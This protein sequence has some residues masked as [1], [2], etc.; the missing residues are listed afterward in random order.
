MLDFKPIPDANYKHDY[1]E[2]FAYVA[3]GKIKG[4][5]TYRSLCLDDLF[6]LLYFGLGRTDCNQSFVIDVIRQVEQD[7]DN[8]LDLWAREHYKSTILTL[9][10]P[11]QE[12]MKNP[13]ER[14]SIFSHTRPIAKAFLRQIKQ[15][16][17]ADPWFKRWF[18]DV[19]YVNPKK[20]SPK[21][22][23]DDGIIVKR[24]S[25]YN[26]S[27]VEAWGLVDGQPTSKH[28]T[29]R[30][31]DDI[32]TK[33][34]VSTSDQIKKTI[35]AYELSQSLGTDGGTER[36][37]GT[38]YHWADPYVHLKKQGNHKVRIKP[39]I[40]RRGNPVFLTSARL[41]EL[42]RKQGKYIFACQQLL[43]P[44]ADEDQIF[45]EKWL[46]YYGA[47]PARLNK[48]LLVDPA[49]EKKEDSDY[50]CMAVIGVD[51]LRNRFLL[52]M[53]FDKLGLNERWVKLKGLIEN[54]APIS[55][56]GYE[57]YG[58]QADTAYIEEK[59][60]DTK[61]YFNLIPLAGQTKKTDRIKRLQPTF[62]NG[63]F[64]L[65]SK[66][67]YKP[68]ANGQ[69]SVDLVKIFIEEEYNFFP[70]C[71]HFDMLDCMSRIE[72]ENLHVTYPSLELHNQ[73]TQQVTDYNMFGN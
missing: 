10:L 28:F 40:D 14:I 47:L 35:D 11:I 30:I 3:A 72:D 39:A 62:Q 54:H 18:P 59:K 31:Y 57:K 65:P 8:T 29:I 21:W 51:A 58:M 71:T 48:Y 19:F 37:C 50:T 6:F 9:A 45:R 15:T 42:K 17:E 52:D 56:I 33:E 20:Q 13:E 68:I 38:H 63:A 60:R 7:H 43:K 2:I 61:V 70:F 55:A 34:S 44:V 23:E 53:V 36:I 69:P 26:E 46:R 16:L 22:S 41:A 24:K 12:I 73:Q 32:V 49:H 64:Y 67:I 25:T 27:T 1:N 4:R 66:L 5:S